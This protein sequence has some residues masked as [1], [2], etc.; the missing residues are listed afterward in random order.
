LK[1]ENQSHYV[2]IKHISRLLNLSTHA[3]DDKKRFCPF[4]ECKFNIEK[5]DTHVN[6]CYRIAKEGS[7]LKMPKEGSIMK[8]KNYKNKLKRPFI[9]YADMEATLEIIDEK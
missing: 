5:Y 3:G 7:I 8:F 1:T 2:Y 9:V 4:C 6:T